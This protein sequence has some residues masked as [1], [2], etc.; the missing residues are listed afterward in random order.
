LAATFNVDY[1]KLKVKFL[2]DTIVN[3]LSQ[4]EFPI[5][6]LKVAEQKIEYL[7]KQKV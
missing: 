3:Y 4:E 2:S 7:I 5:E 1:K 6:V